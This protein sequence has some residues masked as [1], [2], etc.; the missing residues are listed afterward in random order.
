MGGNRDGG[1]RTS[2]EALLERVRVAYEKS[3]RCAACKATIILVEAY[4][5]QLIGFVVVQIHFGY[6]TG[7]ADCSATSKISKSA[8]RKFGPCVAVNR[9]T[10]TPH[11]RMKC[12]IPQKV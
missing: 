5:E 6:D 9:R 7:A 12:L 4:I 11:S 3:C 8:S 10:K 2:S 1:I